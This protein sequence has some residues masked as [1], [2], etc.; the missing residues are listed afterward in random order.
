VA[1]RRPWEGGAVIDDYTMFQG[2]GAGVGLT[3][4]AGLIQLMSPMNGNWFTDSRAVATVFYK[5]SGR[6]NSMGQ[7]FAEAEQR[8][9]A[10]ASRNAPSRDGTSVTTHILPNGASA[11]S[12]LSVIT[13]GVVNSPGVEPSRPGDYPPPENPV[14]VGGNIGQPS[15]LVHVDPVLPPAAAQANVR[16][17]VIVQITIDT[18]GAVSDA[19]VLRSI[20]LLDRAAVDAVRQWRFEP[21]QLN[22]RPVPVIMTVTVNFP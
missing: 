21:T 3:T 19:K 10:D 17:V 9:V 20:P 11:T 18:Q 5:G 13:G 8:A 16:G 7:S 1:A 14:R 22:G 15:K 12:L 6:S 2:G 4:P